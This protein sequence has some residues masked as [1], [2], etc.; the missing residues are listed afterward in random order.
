MGNISTFHTVSYDKRK[1]FGFEIVNYPNLPGNI[2]KA[3][4]YGVFISQWVRFTI[5]NDNSESF[6]KDAKNMVNKLITQG[7]EKQVLKTKYF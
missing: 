1:D 5:I 6:P 7:F 4:S 3:Q 2:P